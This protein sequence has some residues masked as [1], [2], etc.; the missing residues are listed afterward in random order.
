M[1][2]HFPIP[3][4]VVGVS[5]D[6]DSYKNINLEREVEIPVLPHCGA[7]SVCRSHDVHEGVDLY[8]P[9]ATP[10]FAVEDGV[11]VLIRCFTGK[12]AHCDWWEETDAISIEGRS[13]NVEYGEIVVHRRL[14]LR[15]K[16]KKGEIIGHVKRVLKKDK[17]RPTS[18]LHLNLYEGAQTRDQSWELDD[19]S[20]DR[21]G[22]KP[23]GLI[24]PTPFL[25]ESMESMINGR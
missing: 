5:S 13:G 3:L 12:Y 9:E 22:T 8:C 18:M 23:T 17:G 24:D 6:S 25:I 16:V 14:H 2:W 19:N 10:V 15:D 4:N 11:V 1:A 20:P 7:Y 21:R